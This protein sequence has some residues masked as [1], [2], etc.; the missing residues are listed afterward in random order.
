LFL[1]KAISHKCSPLLRS[2]LGAVRE[3]VVLS[4]TP[5]AL[6]QALKVVLIGEDAS[7]VSEI[8]RNLQRKQ[9]CLPHPPDSPFFTA[10]LVSQGNQK[11]R[12]TNRYQGILLKTGV[13][14]Y[15][16]G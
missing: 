2:R 9:L 15:L 7:V 5:S 16:R 10:P 8:K 13:F 12:V 1:L 6:T 11:S 4:I 14:T 3:T